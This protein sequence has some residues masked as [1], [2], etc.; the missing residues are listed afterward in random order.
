M[1]S[2]SHQRK[3]QIPFI[4][5]SICRASKQSS[6]HAGRDIVGSRLVG[7]NG[8]A[9]AD[10]YRTACPIYVGSVWASYLIIEW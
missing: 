1:Y 8:D 5:P 9:H 2:S 6:H 7:P 4:Y 10:G 3:L